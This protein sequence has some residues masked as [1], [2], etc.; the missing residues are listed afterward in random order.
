MGEGHP[1][2]R[3][4]GGSGHRVCVPECVFMMVCVCN[5]LFLCL[6]ANVLASMFGMGSFFLRVCV[7]MVEVVYACVLSLC[8]VYLLASCVVR[9]CA[10]ILK[11]VILCVCVRISECV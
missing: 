10:C 11:R 3:G 1:R 9:V 2:T 5:C 6:L 4:H 8:Y 7:H